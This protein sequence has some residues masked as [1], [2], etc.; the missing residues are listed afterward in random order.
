MRNFSTLYGFSPNE[1]SWEFPSGP[2]CD[3]HPL[4]LCGLHFVC[5]V[6]DNGVLCWGKLRKGLSFRI[7]EVNYH[8]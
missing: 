7:Y 4:P 1:W 5:G 8:T 2:H 6:G 3:A